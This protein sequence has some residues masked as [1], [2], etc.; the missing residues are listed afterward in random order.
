MKPYKNIM[1]DTGNKMSLGDL[2]IDDRIILKCILKL[3]L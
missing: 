1:G 2:D 3:R